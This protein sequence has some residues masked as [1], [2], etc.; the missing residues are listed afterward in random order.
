MTDLL[1]PD[2]PVDHGAS[3]EALARA[4]L[5][6][7]ADMPVSAIDLAAAADV[8]RDLLALGYWVAPSPFFAGGGRS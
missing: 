3:V 2:P 1:T 7:P 6:R 4:L 8:E 5:K